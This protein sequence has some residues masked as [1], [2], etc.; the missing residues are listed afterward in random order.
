V[1][2][3]SYVLEVNG[4]V[5]FNAVYADDVFAAAAAAMLDRAARD[6][7]ERRLFTAARGR[8][9]SAHPAASPAAVGM[10]CRIDEQVG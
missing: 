6:H 2:G 4:A 9:R 8:G 5:D 3:R 10:P 7:A 1:S